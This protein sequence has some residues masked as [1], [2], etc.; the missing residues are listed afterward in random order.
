MHRQQIASRVEQSYAGRTGHAGQPRT[1]IVEQR[2]KS[3]NAGLV[4]H[5]KLNAQAQERNAIAEL[6]AAQQ[7]KQ[8]AQQELAEQHRVELQLQQAQLEL[9]KQLA[10]QQKLLAQQT[11]TQQVQ[12]LVQHED[13]ELEK[14]S[15]SLSRRQKKNAKKRAKQGLIPLQLD[16]KNVNYIDMS[17]N[18]PCLKLQCFGAA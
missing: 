3:Q 9:Q 1:F 5:G 16:M 18:S 10:I 2:Q 4:R 7:E 14:G 12:Q 15:N 17:L 11:Q 6:Q 8:Q 13:S